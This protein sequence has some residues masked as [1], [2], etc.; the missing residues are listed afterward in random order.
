MKCYKLKRL[1]YKEFVPSLRSLW[2]AVYELFAETFH[3]T[4]TVAVG[5]QQ[6]QL[7]I[8]FY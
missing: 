7:E 4:N 1:I 6:K 5:N 3:A 8:T 2:P